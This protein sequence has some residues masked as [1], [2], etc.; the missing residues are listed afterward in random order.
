MEP[1]SRCFKIFNCHVALRGCDSVA[2]AQQDAFDP[3]SVMSGASLSGAAAPTAYTDWQ[4]EVVFNVGLPAVSQAW[5]PRYG[6]AHILGLTPSGTDIRGNVT[7]LVSGAA[8]HNFG[9]R[10]PPTGRIQA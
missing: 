7:V 1:A 9:A 10:S 8:F 3:L 4:G 5:G 2:T 6:R